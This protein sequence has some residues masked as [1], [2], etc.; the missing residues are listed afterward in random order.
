MLGGGCYM[1]TNLSIG[2]LAPS[3]S[4]ALSRASRLPS[5]DGAYTGC[6]L[7]SLVRIVVVSKT[8]AR[9]LVGPDKLVWEVVIV[10]SC[11]DGGEL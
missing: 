2:R 7:S 4:C 11:G 10:C 5:S 3:K 9:S 8:G 1:R 6:T